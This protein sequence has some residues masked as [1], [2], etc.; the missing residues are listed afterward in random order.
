MKTA[1]FAGIAV[2]HAAQQSKTRP[3]M[4]I[5]RLLQDMQVEL[6]TELEDD[7]AV[8][9]K[10]QCWCKTGGEDKKNE[11]EM[12]K[13]TI[14]NLN[15]S[16]DGLVAK[17]EELK[18][19]RKATLDEVNANHASK[20]EADEQRIKENKAFQGEET[21]LIEAVKACKQ[22]LIVLGNKA[23]S[24][25]QVRDAVRSLQLARIPQMVTG[26][27][28]D[29][30]SLDT[31]KQ[32]LGEGTSFLQI[33]GMKS[34]APQS[35]QI[36]GIL[37]QM[38]VDFEKNLKSLQEKEAKAVSE[39]E[40]MSAAKQDEIKAGRE[41]VTQI[42]SDL[43]ALL[44]KH[45]AQAKEIKDTQEQ[46]SNAETFLATL[47]EKCAN[48]EADYE[49]RVKDR[50]VEITAVEDTIKI[51]NDDEAFDAFDK[52]LNHEDQTGS[53]VGFLQTDSENRRDRASAVLRGA[54]MV[55][56]ASKV[57]LD[58]FTEVKAE[59]DK[60][61]AEYK[62]Q[63]ED[64]IAQRDE[65]IADFNDNDRETTHNYDKKDALETKIADLTKTIETS[66]ADKA[67]AAKEIEETKVMM[68]RASENREKEN[69]DNVN[70]VQAQ[71]VTQTI[72][73]KALDR[74]KEAYAF[75]QGPGAPHTQTS[76]TKTDPG[77]GP[78]KFKQYDENAGGKRVLTMLEDVMSD[79][80]QMENEALNSETNAQ[81]AYEILIKDSN[82]LIVTNTK[83]I[84][85]LSETLAK[86]KESLS[87]SKADLVDT[88]GVL[89]ELNDVKGALHKSCD[90]LMKNFEVR[91][92]ARS[93]EIDAMIEAKNILSGM[94]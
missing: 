31:L 4:K 59:I 35:G 30:R 24:L 39:Y 56:L 28:M 37:D 49:K 25:T 11:I 32:F 13:A 88:V 29:R 62:K 17:M 21:D 14:A 83:K 15:S 89:G 84:T 47:E 92:A 74:M 77:N 12:C 93:A 1:L 50:M 20:T 61:V 43:A 40:A 67:E 18:E 16:N 80:K 52:S 70:T 48:A 58:A 87:Q 19:K 33:P 78:A 2:A 34:Y 94:K 45:A 55:G 65:C 38:Q 27:T 44:E 81:A 85:N 7:K 75:L 90:Y 66:T 68:K 73:Q 54:A 63:N 53:A 42:D 71:R 51:L 5:V 72:L 79:S 6:Q 26:S 91:Q 3:V 22:A 9:E 36:V 76:A 69:F 82:K 41:T 46:Q 10:L 57:Q 86:A 60:L 23:A 8:F 64:E